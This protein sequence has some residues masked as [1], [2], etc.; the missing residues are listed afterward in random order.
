MGT[1][2]NLMFAGGVI[3]ATGSYGNTNTNTYLG[4]S[5]GIGVGAGL[6]QY[7]IGYAMDNLNIYGGYITSIAGDGS[8]ACIGGGYHAGLV[9]VNIYGGTIFANE[10]YTTSS[11]IWRGPGIGGGGGGA[12]S[13]ATAG[14]NIYIY[15]GLIY[16]ASE[17]GAA[18]GSGAGGTSGIGQTAY[19]E[20]HGG[21]IHA[22]T[23][24]GTGNGAGAD[25]LR[26][27]RSRPQRYPRYYQGPRRA[28][29]NSR[30]ERR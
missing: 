4:G 11:D 18:I 3:T 28:G 23:T 27:F 22:T 9:N 8:S 26:Q 1:L 13:N 15:D 25:R 14:A 10:K 12:T 6:Q 16:A 7:S 24:K 30:A 5:P 17:F 19:V 20:I 29:G 21:E 2:H